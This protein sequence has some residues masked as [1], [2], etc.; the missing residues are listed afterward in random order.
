MI[1]IH[2][3]VLGDTKDGCP[4][5]FVMPKLKELND[6]SSYFK[7]LDSVFKMFWEIRKGTSLEH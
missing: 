2:V 1:Y 7:N 3:A 4:L 6:V 5:S